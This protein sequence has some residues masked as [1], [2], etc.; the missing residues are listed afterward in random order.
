MS[1]IL[2]IHFWRCPSLLLH[3][4]FCGCH[5]T[6]PLL[7]S[8][9]WWPPT[10]VSPPQTWWFLWWAEKAELS[11]RRGCGRCSDRDWWRHH[12]AQVNQSTGRGVRGYTSVKH[13]TVHCFI[14]ISAHLKRSCQVK[15]VVKTYPYFTRVSCNWWTESHW[16]NIWCRVCLNF[17]KYSKLSFSS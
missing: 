9:L 16:C 14:V 6:R 11:W 3:P 1:S 12:R 13:Q 17:Q 5:G 7:W 10:G 4:S 15:Q 8:T 2:V